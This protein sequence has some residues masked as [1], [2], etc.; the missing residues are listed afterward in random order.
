MQRRWVGFPGLPPI[1][2]L[3]DRVVCVGQLSAITLPNAGFGPLT[4]QSS[5]VV[6]NTNGRA[7]WREG[8]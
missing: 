4:S 5:T 8:S 2:V 3:P 7:G 1:R 6:H